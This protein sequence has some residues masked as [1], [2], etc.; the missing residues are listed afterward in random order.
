MVTTS[1]LVPGK[2]IMSY[3]IVTGMTLFS[4]QIEA[5]ASSLSKKARFTSCSWNQPGTRIVF[6]TSHGEVIAV[7]PADSGNTYTVT[8]MTINQGGPVQTVHWHGPV[9]QCQNEDSLSYPS[10]KLSTYLRNGD[11]VFFQTPGRT[12]RVCSN[13]GIVDGTAAWNLDQSLL[14]VI[15]YTRR[16]EP[17]AGFLNTQGDV[18]F[19]VSKDLPILPTSQVGISNT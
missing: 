5:T 1:L 4:V 8:T 6:G 14:V 10:Q 7:R 12:E 18:V 3:S 19:T 16:S 2:A 13:T 17:I 15:G 11:C 9:L